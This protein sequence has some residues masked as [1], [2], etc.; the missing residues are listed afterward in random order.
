M[1]RRLFV[2]VNP[3]HARHIREAGDACHDAVI[4]RRQRKLALRIETQTT[5]PPAEAHPEANQCDADGGQ[6]CD[7]QLHPEGVVVS[8]Y[9]GRV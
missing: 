9:A 5:V 8:R 3:F 4:A 6:R 2:S 7:D 1:Y